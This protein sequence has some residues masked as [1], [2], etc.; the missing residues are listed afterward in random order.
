MLRSGALNHNAKSFVYSTIM[1]VECD[2]KG[3]INMHDFY[4]KK[5]CGGN[6]IWLKSTFQFILIIFLLSYYRYV[7]TSEMLSHHQGKKR[8]Q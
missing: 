5:G 7:H 1:Y 6:E 3:I 4:S 2:V 8:K